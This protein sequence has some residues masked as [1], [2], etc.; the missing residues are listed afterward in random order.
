MLNNKGGDEDTLIFSTSRQ[1]CTHNMKE[2]LI[3][4]YQ[5]SGGLMERCYTL[6]YR[7]MRFRCIV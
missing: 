5:I 6:T 3:K 4:P 7:A 1:E 2:V